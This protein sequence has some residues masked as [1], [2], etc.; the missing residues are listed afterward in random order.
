M[1]PPLSC[2]KELR[3]AFGVVLALGQVY[4]FPRGVVGFELAKAPHKILG[5]SSTRA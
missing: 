5:A 3:K 1:F 2:G 4:D